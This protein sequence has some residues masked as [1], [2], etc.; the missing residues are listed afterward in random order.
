M[1]NKSREDLKAAIEILLVTHPGIFDGS[2][3]IKILASK[4]AELAL[5]AL[6][7]EGLQ[8][9]RR[10]VHPGYKIKPTGLY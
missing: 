8:F 10:P 2:T 1:I 7:A 5:Q 9:Q 3:D 6:E 4:A